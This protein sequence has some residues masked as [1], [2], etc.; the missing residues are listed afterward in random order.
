MFLSLVHTAVAVTALAVSPEGVPP[1]PIN[2]RVLVITSTDS[3]NCAAE[4]SRLYQSGGVFDQMRAVG[5]KIGDNEANHL[6]VVDQGLVPDVVQQIEIREFPIVLCIEGTEIVRSF[7]SGCT[8]PLDAWTFSWLAKGIYER[9]YVEPTE[10]ARVATTGNYPLRGNHWSID[11][12]VSPS[13]EKLVGHLRA[14]THGPQVRADYA[15]ESWSYEELRSLHDNLHEIEMG[16]W[17]PS[18][19]AHR[20]QP[21]TSSISKASGKALGR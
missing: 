3:A 21:K 8:T 11:G 17:Q 5:W 16:G 9:P 18:Y 2:P 1:R 7:R 4:M 13:R 15:I 19:Y 12:D 6:Q 20:S 10:A 14:P